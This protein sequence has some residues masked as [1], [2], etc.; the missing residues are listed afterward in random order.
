MVTRAVWQ[1]EQCGRGAGWQWEGRERKWLAYP[2]RTRSRYRRRRLLLEPCV[3][4]TL[5]P[6]VPGGT[7]RL[8]LRLRHLLWAPSTHQLKGQVNLSARHGLF[9]PTPPVLYRIN[10][11]AIITC[12]IS[13][14]FG[15][16]VTVLCLRTC[17]SVIRVAMYVPYRAHLTH[18]FVLLECT[19]RVCENHLRLHARHL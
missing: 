8:K 3:G 12:A 13:S 11:V 6:S 16:H 10:I 5:W 14:A 2:L 4:R 9:A 19:A 7:R 15:T 17:A 18:M 1:Q